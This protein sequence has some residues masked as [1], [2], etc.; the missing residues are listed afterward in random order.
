[1]SIARRRLHRIAFP[2]PLLLDCRAGGKQGEE[3]HGSGVNGGRGSAVLREEE[4]P[5]CLVL[6]GRDPLS[7]LE[8][9]R[10]E[11]VER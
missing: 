10:D 8:A 4:L 5:A 3:G 1:M 6:V 9:R 7:L 11:R 2:I